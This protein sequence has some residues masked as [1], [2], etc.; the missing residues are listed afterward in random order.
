MAL[1][2]DRAA[3]AAVS[4]GGM[5]GALAR[6]G[7]AAA[8]PHPPGGFPWS[9]WVVNVSGCFLIGVLNTRVERRL[10]RLFLGTGVLGGYTTFSTAIAET[11]QAGLI[12]LAATLAG[13]VLAVLAG[14]L[15]AR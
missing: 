6:F 3:L 11:S 13:A 14:S 2:V 4:T 8:L 12:Y 5:L 10:P 15:L 9:T 7:I 1:D